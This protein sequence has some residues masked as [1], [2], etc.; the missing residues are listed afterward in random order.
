MTQTDAQTS[1]RAGAELLA[2]AGLA[3]V[4]LSLLAALAAG[5]PL[6][7]APVLS[8]LLAGLGWALRTRPADIA[9]PGLALTT[10]AQAMVLTAGLTG[11][12]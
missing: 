5:T 7:L 6:W 1:E 2:R 10:M 8:A 3:F 11:H 12:P 4:G 9:G